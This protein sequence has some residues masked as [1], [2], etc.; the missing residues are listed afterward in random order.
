MRAFAA[1][2]QQRLIPILIVIELFS[3]S[4]RFGHTAHQSGEWVLLIDLKFGA[5]F[6]LALR[7]L[8]MQVLGWIQAGFVRYILGGFPCRSF[9]RAR[10]AP[11]GPPALRDAL[12]VSGLPDL[13]PGDELNVQLGNNLLW[14]VVRVAEACILARTP[15]VLENPWTAWSWKMQRMIQLLRSKHVQLSRTDFC[16]WGTPWLKATGFLTV[17]C[18]PQHIVRLCRSRGSC[19]RTQRPHVVL[20]GTNSAGVHLTHLAEP[21]PKSLCIKL[22]QMC[23]NASLELQSHRLDAVFCKFC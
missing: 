15:C 22:V 1:G 12:H 13:R 17:Y 11:N 18:Q 7:K 5:G 8:Q 14:F 4:S 23:K 10:N 16:M 6:D 19:A 9:S 20:K 2:L 21:Y 3:G